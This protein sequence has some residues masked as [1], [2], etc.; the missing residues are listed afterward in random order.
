MPSDMQQHIRKFHRQKSLRTLRAWR[1]GKRTMA[2][3]TNGQTPTRFST[4]RDAKTLKNS[5]APAQVCSAT[6][7]A[8]DVGRLKTCAHAEQLSGRQVNSPKTAISPL[9]Q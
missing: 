9:A 3:T 8:P 2:L 5:P 7:N 4:S 1:F 6:P